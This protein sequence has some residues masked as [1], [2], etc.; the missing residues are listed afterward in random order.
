MPTSPAIL[1][2]LASAA[3]R[4]ASVKRYQINVYVTQHPEFPVNTYVTNSGETA[5]ACVAQL[6]ANP[7]AGLSRV[8]IMDSTQVLPLLVRSPHDLD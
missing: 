1:S 2:L 4:F 8:E 7:T 3:E 6:L 5:S